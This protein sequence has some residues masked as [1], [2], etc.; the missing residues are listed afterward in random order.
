[1]GSFLE[2]LTGRCDIQILSKKNDFGFIIE[3]KAYIG[4]VSSS[5]LFE[6]SEMALKQIIDNRYDEELKN[7]GAKKIIA[8]GFAFPKKHVKLSKK[9]V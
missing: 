6:Y 5:R 7:R 4:N 9:A 1:M 3:V 2:C 8:Y